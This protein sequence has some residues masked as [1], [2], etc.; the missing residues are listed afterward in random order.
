MDDDVAKFEKVLK[1]FPLFLYSS[2]YV[3]LDILSVIG[4]KRHITIP[5]KRRL[6]QL[7]TACNAAPP[8]NFKMAA[9]GE[10]NG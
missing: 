10:K 6:G 5:A 1:V 2:E 7:L 3:F 4:V 8:T 9:R